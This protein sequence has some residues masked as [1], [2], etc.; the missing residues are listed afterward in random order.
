MKSKTL[1]FTILALLC[2]AIGLAQGPPGGGQG[3]RGDRQGGPPK[4]EKPEASEI[5]KL[6]D[7]NG[8]DKIDKEEASKDERGKIAKDFDVIDTNEDGFIDLEELKAE[9]ERK[10]PR[11]VSAKKLLKE[12]DQDEDGFLNELEIAAKDRRDLMEHF[13]EIDLNEDGQ[14][15]LEELE[16]F[17]DAKDDDKKKRKRKN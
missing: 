6:L 4:G 13:S 10:G 16:T 17:Y 11:K 15:D 2:S 3:G 1:A 7:T 5:L 9:I 12:V 14:L 8:D